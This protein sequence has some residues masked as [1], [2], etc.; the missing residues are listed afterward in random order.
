MKKSLSEL[1]KKTKKDSENHL[2]IMLR[3]RQKIELLKGVHGKGTKDKPGNIKDSRTAMALS[4]II[5]PQGFAHL[6]N[7]LSIDKVLSIKDIFGGKFS[8]PVRSVPASTLQALKSWLA[9]Q[10]INNDEADNLEL[11]LDAIP[12]DTARSIMREANA[13]N[14]TRSN[15]RKLVGRNIYKKFLR[16][17][18]QIKKADV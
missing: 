2:T 8:N 12:A 16:K 11:F 4:G 1:W 15:N 6:K 10:D 5:G 13:G 9:D 14:I 17:V 18:V 3:A 7:F